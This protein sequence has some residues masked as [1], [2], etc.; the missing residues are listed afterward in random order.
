MASQPLE[1]L[2][3]HTRQ[4]REWLSNGDDITMKQLAVINWTTAQVVM[5]LADTMAGCPAL[6]AYGAVMRRVVPAVVA[7][8]LLAIVGG[9]AYAIQAGIVLPK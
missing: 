1:D 3:E 6:K 8:L 9:L 7:V 4:I 2:R 5:N